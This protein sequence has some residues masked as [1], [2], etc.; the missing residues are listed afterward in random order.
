MTTKSIYITIVVLV[1]NILICLGVGIFGIFQYLDLKELSEELDQLNIIKEDLMITQQEYNLTVEK[2]SETEKEIAG[3]V[4]F[5]NQL[6]QNG[7][8]TLEEL[9]SNFNQEKEA[10]NKELANTTEQIEEIDGEIEIAFGNVEESRKKVEG[11]QEKINIAKQQQREEVDL[12]KKQEKEK[13]DLKNAIKKTEAEREDLKNALKEGEYL[14]NAWEDEIRRKTKKTFTTL[15]SYC[16]DANNN[17]TKHEQKYKDI[18]LKRLGALSFYPSEFDTQ[19]HVLQN[20]FSWEKYEDKFKTATPQ[21]TKDTLK[22]IGKEIQSIANFQ[23]AD[24]QF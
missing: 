8:L 23:I 3:R 22:E 20:K 2:L 13:E 4:S 12:I 21:E 16:S 5:L 19:F 24:F 7:N 10:L 17:I 18:F 9:F 6:L 11:V 1:V 14:E 15:V